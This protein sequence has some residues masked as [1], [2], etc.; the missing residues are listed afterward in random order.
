DPDEWFPLTAD[1][2]R[3]RE[4]AARAIAVCAGCPV[5]ADC[6]ELSLRHS[7]GIG[8]Y[9]VWG[10]L[11]AEERRALRRRRLRECSVAE[12]SAAQL[13]GRSLTLVTEARDL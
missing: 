13:P 8:A 5:R 2:R 11:V 1:V 4:Q 6:L 10:G 7:S 9:G 12:D 3:A